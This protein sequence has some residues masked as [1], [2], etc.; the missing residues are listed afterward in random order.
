MGIC[1]ILMNYSVHNSCIR[2]LSGRILQI[3]SSA[4]ADEWQYAPV[5][6]LRHSYCTFSINL[7][8][9]SCMD[10]QPATAKS[11]CGRTKHLY[12]LSHFY[13]DAFSPIKQSIYLSKCWYGMVWYGMVYKG[14]TS[15]SSPHSIGHF[16]DGTVSCF[17]GNIF[18]LNIKSQM[19]I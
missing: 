5:I 7:T 13:W 11:K 10:A 4:S 19:I 17:G 14:L 18:T 12:N 8:P 16:G 2:I 6:C 3:T 1:R 9:L 15:H